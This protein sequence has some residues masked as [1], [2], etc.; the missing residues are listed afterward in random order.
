MR[1]G[2]SKVTLDHYVHVIGDAERVA[3]ERFSRKIGPNLT[4]MESEPQ[5]ESVK[6]KSA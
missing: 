6:T 4:Q 3:S 2:D 1:H 5:L